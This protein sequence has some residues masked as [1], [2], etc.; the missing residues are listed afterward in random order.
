MAEDKKKHVLRRLQEKITEFN[1]PT[2]VEKVLKESKST[3]EDLVKV[4]YNDDT[5]DT[6]DWR[7]EFYLCKNFFEYFADQYGYILDPKNKRVFAFKAHKFQ[8][9]LI[10][11]TILNNLHVIFRK[12]LTENNFVQ[13]DRGYISIKDVKVGDLIQTIKDGSITWDE[14]V[15]KW[16]NEVEKEIVKIKLNNG[17]L[18]E[19]TLD[20]KCMTARGW[21]ESK[22]LTVSDEL[23][24][25]FGMNS[26]GDFQLAND[27]QAKLIGYLLTDGRQG[28][29]FIN[30]NVDYI[31]EALECG[32]T[33]GDIKPYIIERKKIE[34][35]KQLYEVKFTSQKHTNKSNSYIEFCKHF[36]LDEIDINKSLSPELMNLNRK[37][38]SIL[39]NRLYAGDGWASKGFRESP[40]GKICYKASIGFVTPNKKM[41]FQIQEILRRYGISAYL[42]FRKPKSNR[43]ANRTVH[44]YIVEIT[45]KDSVLKF[46]K[47]IGIKNKIDRNFVEFVENNYK[48][49]IQQ[50]LT[51]IKKI[52][53]LEPQKTYDITTKSCHSFLANGNLV[54]NCRQQGLSV[55]CGI[56]AI[57]KVN[58][59]MAQDVMIISRTGKDARDFKAKAMVTYDRLPEFLK[60]KA[61]RDGQNMSTLK[62]LNQSKMEVRT[63]AED[64]GRGVTAS[65]LILDECAFMQYADE[66]WGSAFPSL[67]NTG[68]QCFII[69]TAN[70]V[71]NF[72]HQKWLQA[73]NGESDFEAV[74]VPWW[75][76]PGRDNDWS[77]Y[78]SDHQQDQLES[79]LGT[80]SVEQLKKDLAEEKENVPDA[81]WKRLVDLYVQ[82]K[83]EEAINYNG[84]GKKPWLKIQRDELG[85]RKFNQEILSRFLG[86]GNTV[87][88]IEA[89]ERIS[90]QIREPLFTDSLDDREKIKGLYVFQ[91]SVS[92]ITY[93]MTVDV[94]SGAGSDYSTFQVFRDDSLE[95]VAEYKQQIDNKSFAAI[96]KKVGKRYNL[97]YVIIETNQG[98]SVFNELYLDVNDPYQNMLYEFKNRSYRGLH[99]GP[100]NKKL[101]LDEFMMNIENNHIKI[102]GKR[103]LEEM[104]VYIW[105]N[106]KPQAST[107]YNDDLVLPIMFLAYLLK[108]GEQRMTTLGFATATQTVGVPQETMA[109]ERVEEL[110][111]FKEEE[112]KRAVKDMYGLDW[113]VYEWLQK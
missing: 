21:V 85:P 68:G 79:E 16:E 99:T 29:A 93:T 31:N 62:L 86:S 105:H 51:K 50:S 80:I 33:F 2:T 37:Q 19:S 35:R 61:T 3:C 59:N 5:V 63:A 8:R 12:C 47:E 103:T 25:N 7:A 48:Y 107:G 34:S 67:S 6:V 28:K 55:I 92:D 60:T 81:Y 26:F 72:Y 64:S 30:S 22:D 90:E 32:H 57:W 112:A 71:G 44:T 17:S 40:T 18:L 97:A 24:T 76:Y 108:Y 20:H 36:N 66:I 94:A 49:E 70:G 53:K 84:P 11:P 74:Y 82:K 27:E 54:H 23:V 98:M 101:M 13:T 39:L 56:Y 9:E 75:K 45:R 110:K 83:E 14:V 89:L 88:S 113:E 78:I 91:S 111:Y 106:N 1:L 52:E 65:L 87:V 73:E 10:I 15:D 102:Y 58:F 96:I 42:K 95:Q 69:S 104:Q 4:K 41:A 43:F 38:M 46:A 109:D 77:E 100:A